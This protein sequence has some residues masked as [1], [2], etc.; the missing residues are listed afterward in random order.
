MH[1][2]NEQKLEARVI[3]AAE[4]AVSR[5]QYVSP[6][7]VLC[8]MGLLAPRQVES[9]RKGRIDYLERVIQGNLKKISL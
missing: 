8:G 4:G 2:D 1:P 9:W 7:D 6:I 3:Q 5:Q